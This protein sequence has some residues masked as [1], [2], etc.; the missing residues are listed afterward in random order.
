MIGKTS[1]NPVPT[2]THYQWQVAISST[3]PWVDIS[4]SDV[5]DYKP[6]APATPGQYF[7]RRLVRQ[8]PF[9]KGFCVPAED[10]TQT[11]NV[12]SLTFSNNKSHTT[13]IPD[14]KYGICKG[15]AA[16][17]L[18]YTLTPS[19]DGSFAPY[20]YKLTSTANLA[21]TVFGQSGTVAAAPGSIN[22][23]VGVA[24]EYILQVTDSRGCV[25]FDT[26]KIENLTLDAGAAT[27]FTCGETS[28][29]IG[30]VSLPPTYINYPTNN[31]AW[32]PA[33]GLDN[34]LSVSPTFTHG[35][36]VGDSTMKYLTFNGCIVDSIKI[37][38]RSITP[39]PTLPDLSVCQG[40]TLRLGTSG[41]GT[42]PV[43]VAQSGVTYQWAPGLGLTSNSVANPLVTTIFA[44]QGVN[45]IT[46]TVLATAGNT[47]CAQTTTQKL[48][49]YREPNQSF[50]LKQCMSNGC[51]P[52]STLRY[53]IFGTDA[54]SPISYSWTVTVVD[55]PDNT[56]TTK[57]TNQRSGIS[58]SLKYKCF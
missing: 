24:G 56:G 40:D 50:N 23:N 6:E 21:T 31:F 57:L 14:G 43:L 11:S 33:T 37:V 35:L 7:Y 51:T 18:S 44:P 12:V 47:G 2:P 48:T 17:A 27:K 16:L 55:D 46:Y 36:A 53:G 54:E 39:L 42:A 1:A 28:V 34:P 32:S 10:I 52:D 19:S 13:N 15:G 58:F 5:E 45:E 25:S 41:P 9:G 3:G 4:D 26:L 49:T 8:T 20:N 29:K 22:L 30:P 38:N